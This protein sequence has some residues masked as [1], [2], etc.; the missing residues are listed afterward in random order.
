M[1]DIIDRNASP[2]EWWKSNKKVFPNLA[3]M[4]SKFLSATASTISSE[5]L[6]S[7][8]GNVFESKRNSLSPENGEK[9][10]FLQILSTR[11][12]LTL[13]FYISSCIL[14]FYTDIIFCILKC[15]L[16]F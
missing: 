13:L 12:L 6:F 10:V 16:I 9:L 1:M 7:E 5:Q 2:L 11:Q 8:A 3:L 4:A 15:I 14:I